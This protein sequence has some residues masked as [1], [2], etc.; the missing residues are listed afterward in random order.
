MN[1]AYPDGGPMGQVLWHATMSLDGFIAGPRDDLTWL[2][3]Y[4]GPNPTA[5]QVQANVGALL[6]GDRTYQVAKTEEG[7]S[8]GGA[9]TGPQFVLSHHPPKNSPAG[10]TFSAATLR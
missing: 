10:F 6:I 5:D 8:Y 2:A 7:K 3:D 9:W 4:L 1:D